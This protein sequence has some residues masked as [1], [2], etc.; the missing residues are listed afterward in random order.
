MSGN[1]YSSL[2][3]MRNSFDLLF[4]TKKNDKKYKGKLIPY[5]YCIFMETIKN[6]LSHSLEL[7]WTIRKTSKVNKN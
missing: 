4:S 6:C 5:E 3:I 1:D 7:N 2:K